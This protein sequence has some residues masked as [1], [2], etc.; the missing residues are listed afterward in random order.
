MNLII[1]G[2]II[3]IGKIIPGVSGAMLAMSLGI[4]EKLL[5]ILANLKKE[6]FENMEYIIK[7]GIGIIL[8]II[9]ASKIIVN[10]LNN[11]YFT[12]MLLFIGMII[13]GIPNYIKKTKLKKSNILVVILLLIIIGILITLINPSKYQ[14][15]LEYNLSNFIKLIGVG[16][17]DAFSCIVPGISGTALLISIGY[18]NLILQT[19][20]NIINVA[21][22][23]NTFFVMTP[24][25]I[26][27]LIG[28]TITSK[29]LNYMFKK[30]KQLMNFLIL[31]LIISTTLTLIKN[32][33]TQPFSLL[34]LILGIILFIVGYII[35][36]KL[37]K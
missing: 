22:I 33:I 13:G 36:T 5:N 32:T 15:S 29:I 25:L 17:I 28:I 4:Y 12:T 6:I 35:S 23:K 34:E 18:Y 2:F 19:F 8:A 3:G 24:F 14:H 30:N 27:F 31:I 9:L 16:I 10:C 1:K 21:E 7:L 11:Y 26:G 20:S 37:D